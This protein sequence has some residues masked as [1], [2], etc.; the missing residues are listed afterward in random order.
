MPHP[1]N[2]SLTS[3][4]ARLIP[5]PILT[6]IHPIPCHFTSSWHNQPLKWSRQQWTDC[7]LCFRT[8]QGVFLTTPFELFDTLRL[9]LHSTIIILFEA[10]PCEFSEDL[11]LPV[12]DAANLVYLRSLWKLVNAFA[13]FPR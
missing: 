6:L 3:F 12:P 4:E 2:W 9:K 7:H 11:C 10:F 1:W 13:L 8:G 5:L